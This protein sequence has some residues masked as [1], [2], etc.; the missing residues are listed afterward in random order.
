MLSEK[1]Y[2]SFK[3]PPNSIIPDEEIYER[4]SRELALKL[5]CN[6]GNEQCL[7]DTFFLMKNFAETDQKVPKGL[8]D[9][10]FCSGLRGLNKQEVWVTLWKEMQT[11]SDNT[12]KDQLIAGLGCTDDRVEL[13]DYLESTLG[14]SNSVNYTQAN[15]HSVLNAALNSHSGLEVVTNFM[16]SFESNIIRSFGFQSLEAMITV[17]ARTVKNEE[18]QTLFMDYVVSLTHLDDEAFR[19]VASITFDNLD[20]Q[21]EFPYSY[22]ME[23]I[24]RMLRS[25]DTTTL[26]TTGV[27][28]SRP[29]TEETIRGQ[30]PPS[31]Y[32]NIPHETDCTRYYECVHG[33]KYLR[34]CP[35]GKIFDVVTRVC[36]D[37]EASVCG[38]M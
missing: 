35:D 4:F 32:G 25:G 21:Q 19:R 27:P 11:T 10:V 18:Q 37:A 30:C 7:A 16:K 17:P 36:G 38:V 31:G 29:T 22:Q 9:V 33:I 28:T 14:S 24:R 15:R 20:R 34:V 2:D 6:S 26:G 23:I 13:K 3:L 5:A 8:E 12:L 1:F